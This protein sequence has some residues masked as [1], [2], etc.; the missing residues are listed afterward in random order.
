MN[1]KRSRKYERNLNVENKEKNTYKIE[2][3]IK[4]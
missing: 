1:V 2:A 4:R 3:D